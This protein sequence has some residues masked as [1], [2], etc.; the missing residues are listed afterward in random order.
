MGTPSKNRFPVGHKGAGGVRER[1]KYGD[2]IRENPQRENEGKRNSGR[3]AEEK[4]KRLVS[5]P[6]RCRSCG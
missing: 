5:S 4:R 1:E 2:E 6:F 3:E